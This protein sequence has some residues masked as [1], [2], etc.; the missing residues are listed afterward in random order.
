MLKHYVFNWEIIIN[1]LINWGYDREQVVDGSMP[2]QTLQKIC[3][4]VCGNGLQIGGFVGVSHCFLANAL[5]NKGSICTIDPNITHR[6]IDDPLCAANRLIMNF[7]LSSN[8]M[9]ICGYAMEQMRIL[10]LHK[11]KFDF[12]ILDGNHD[13]DH[14]L[15]ETKMADSLLNPGGHLVLDDIDHWQGPKSLYENFPF[16][17]EKIPLDTRAGVLRKP[18]SIKI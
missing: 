11:V 1:C 3:K 2:D 17:Y 4:I 14:V 13:F 10:G 15:T 5:K 16:N 18:N 8:S 7:N 9:L 6:G 12:I